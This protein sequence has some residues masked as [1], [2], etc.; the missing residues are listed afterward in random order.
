MS[1]RLGIAGMDLR[2]E[3]MFTREQYDRTVRS[4]AIRGV[5]GV[6][7]NT[8]VVERRAAVA[9]DPDRCLKMLKSM[10]PHGLEKA[11]PVVIAKPEPVH[12]VEGTTEAITGPTDVTALIKTALA[13]PGAI[14]DLERGYGGRECAQIAKA[15]A[16]PKEVTA[17]DLE[18]VSPTLKKALGDFDQIVRR[19]VKRAMA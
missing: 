15:A 9:G 4:E 14:E 12:K 19:A 6:A 18:T 10:Q 3:Q 5:A 8:E 7:A 11:E 2:T 17:F 13:S 1:N 16:Q